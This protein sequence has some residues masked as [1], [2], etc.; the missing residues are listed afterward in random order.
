MHGAAYSSAT[1][2]ELQILE[3]LSKQGFICYALDIPGYGQ[4][5]QNKANNNKWLKQII[6][7][8]VGEE[9]EKYIEQNGGVRYVCV[10]EFGLCTS[11]CVLVKVQRER[12]M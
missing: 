4:S 6:G 12:S 7:Q 2:S 10:L 8:L 1:W 3:S 5:V 11:I 9:G